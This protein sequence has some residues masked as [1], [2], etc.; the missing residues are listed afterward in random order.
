MVAL[1]ACGRNDR[2]AVTSGESASGVSTAGTMMADEADDAIERAFEADAELARFDLDASDDTGRVRLTGTVDTDAQ[3]TA[4][5]A[6]AERTA[7]GVPIDNQIT[8]R[9]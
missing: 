1:A 4:A 8:V 2:T 9:R 6:L 3:R 5:G 7:P